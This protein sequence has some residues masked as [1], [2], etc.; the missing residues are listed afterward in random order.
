MGSVPASMD[1][2]RLDSYLSRAGVDSR[3]TCSENVRQGLC[4]VNGRVIRIIFVTFS[5]ICFSAASLP[6]TGL[7]VTT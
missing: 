5:A 2:S 1:G 3:R 6:V 4:S 7:P